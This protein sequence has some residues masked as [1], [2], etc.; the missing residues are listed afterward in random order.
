MEYA[1]RQYSFRCTN[2]SAT[3]GQYASVYGIRCRRSIN[4]NGSINL[5]RYSQMIDGT[6]EEGTKHNL[7]HNAGCKFINVQTIGS[8]PLSSAPRQACRC[9]AIMKV[10]EARSGFYSI[11]RPL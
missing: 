2:Y 9:D 10:W 3:A 11:R 7:F 4:A 5:G 1:A 6:A 8:F